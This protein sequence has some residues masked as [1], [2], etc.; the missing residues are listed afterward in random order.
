MSLSTAMPGS[1]VFSYESWPIRRVLTDEPPL[2]YGERLRAESDCMTRSPFP[3]S[4]R[5]VPWHR[6]MSFD[7]SVSAS[8]IRMPPLRART[9]KARPG[10]CISQR[11]GATQRC[12]CDKSREV[13]PVGS[14][15]SG[16]L[17]SR[18]DLWLAAYGALPAW[19]SRDPR[20][21]DSPTRWAR[22]DS[23][24]AEVPSLR[25][26]RVVD[27]GPKGCVVSRRASGFHD[28]AR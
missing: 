10:P 13:T 6:S 2:H 28:L 4:S 16:S 14:C 24:D 3:C 9:I 12:A 19:A 26:G 22:F 8:R 5:R 11:S 21:D 7:F 25:R 1:P 18:K 17:P 15:Q 27:Q 23:D 20:R